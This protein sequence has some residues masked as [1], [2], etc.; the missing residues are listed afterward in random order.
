MDSSPNYYSNNFRDNV[1]ILARAG[2]NP[3]QFG[4]YSQEIVGKGVTVSNSNIVDATVGVDIKGDTITNL[5][6]VDI[7]DPVAFAV[8]AAGNNNIY[9]NGLDVDDSGLGANTNYGFYT[10][11]TSSGNQEVM[12]S[13]FN[14]LGT[15]S[16][17][18]Q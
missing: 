16:I 5:N 12:N 11:S 15:A 2:D 7:D 10:E 8:R 9:I 3:A 13:N 1:E 4:A 6:N 14:G 17:P 18:D